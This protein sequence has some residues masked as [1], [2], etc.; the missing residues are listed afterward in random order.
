MIGK[1]RSREAGMSF[2]PF[3]IALV[4]VL[5]LVFVWYD[6]TKDTEKIQGDLVRANAEAKHQQERFKAANDA[7]IELVE[8]TGFPNAE[9]KPDKQQVADAI[10][11]FL[12]K[13]REKMTIEFDADRF[14]STGLGGTVEKLSGNRVRVVYLPTKAEMGAV[15]VQGLLP[16]VESSAARMLVDIKRAF[17]ATFAAAAESKNLRDQQKQALDAKDAANADLRNQL[18]AAQQAAQERERELRDQVAAKDAANTQAQAELEAERT[19]SETE[20]ARLTRELNQKTAELRTLARRDAPALSEG[21]DGEVLAASSGLAVLSRGKKDMLMPGTTFTVLGRRK[22]GDLVAKGTVR[23]TLVN[24]LTAE[25]RVVEESATDPI[26]GGDLIQS[27]V[28]SPDRQLR[29]SL[30]GD[31][32]RMGRSQAEARL[33]ALGAAVDSQVTSETHYLVVGAGEN[34][35]ESDSYRRAKEFGITILTEESLSTFTLY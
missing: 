22:G 13:W 20:I 24:E 11:T 34:L 33:K 16:L 2:W 28:Y 12:D 18:A 29:F 3:V 6:G 21:P 17:E 15:S 5:V 1:I 8:V 19:K 35:E 25:A 9:G 10:A 27:V 31:F 14:S 32:R 30:L 23:V 7:L 26:N 4:M